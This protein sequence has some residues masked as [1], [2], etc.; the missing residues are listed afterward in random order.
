MA[1]VRELV[2]LAE[3][4]KPLLKLSHDD[5][6]T[7]DRMYKKINESNDKI[8]ELKEKLHS[9]KFL[10]KEGRMIINQIFEESQNV[11]RL[12]EFIRQQKADAYAEQ[13][14]GLGLL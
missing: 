4:K 6:W 12:N 9:H 3:Y 2:P 11:R 7:I 5:A 1:V 14:K 13:L 8:S 10:K